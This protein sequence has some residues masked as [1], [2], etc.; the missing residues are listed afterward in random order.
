MLI[1]F[2]S[3]TTLFSG[4]GYKYSLPSVSLGNAAC[5]PYFASYFQN[6]GSSFLPNRGNSP[7]HLFSNRVGILCISIIYHFRFLGF[8]I[9]MFICYFALFLVHGKTP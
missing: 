8:L 6:F 3:N 1:F 7:F 9:S 4:S 2:D 5:P